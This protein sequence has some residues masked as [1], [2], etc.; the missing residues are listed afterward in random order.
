MLRPYTTH[1]KI[2][3]I[4]VLQIIAVIA[5]I[6]TGLVSLIN[7][8]R[9]QGFTGLTPQADAASPKSA[10]YLADFSS[11]WASPSFCSAHAKPIKCSASCYLAIARGALSFHLSWT[12]PL[13]S[14]TG[15]AS[16]LKLS[17]ASF[18]YC[19]YEPRRTQQARAKFHVDRFHRARN[20]PDRFSRQKE[21]SAGFQPR[22]FLTFLPTAHG[23]VA[24][25]LR[26]IYSTGYRNCSG[27]T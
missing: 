2:M 4:K 26:Q 20:Q 15:S 10:R 19:Q 25:G 7:P 14:P 23:A 27:R 12:N 16:S 13:C 18:W 3:I 5:T 22:F 6:L 17:S 1:R 11:G 24:P 8:Q 9:V 21:C